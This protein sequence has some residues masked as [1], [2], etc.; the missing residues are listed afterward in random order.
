MR[1]GGERVARTRVTQPTVNY[2]QAPPRSAPRYGTWGTSRTRTPAE[3]TNWLPSSGARLGPPR[4]AVAWELGSTSRAS[5]RTATA[6][7]WVGYAHMVPWYPPWLSRGHRA[8]IKASIR[9][10]MSPNLTINRW[11]WSFHVHMTAIYGCIG[12]KPPW[13][14][15]RGRG[16]AVPA[17]ATCRWARAARRTQRLQEA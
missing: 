3:R 9:T 1:G 11:L 4:Q 17:S 13:C 6:S 15:P 16:Q 5:Q 2:E 10:A 12:C 7:N 8:S 14:V